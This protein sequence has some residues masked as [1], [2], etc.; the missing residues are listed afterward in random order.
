MNRA[1]IDHFRR[2]G[3]VPRSLRYTGT[4]IVATE[5]HCTP[6]RGT[7]R[8][9]VC[10]SFQLLLYPYE[11]SFDPPPRASHANAYD[12]RLETRLP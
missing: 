5:R 1:T 4:A 3:D 10:T 2:P 7:D 11:T 8:R 12:G 6:D 9:S